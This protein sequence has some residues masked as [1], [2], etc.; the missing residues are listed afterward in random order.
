MKKD[1]IKNSIKNQSNTEKKKN[2]ITLHNPTF[3]N[4]P[5]PMHSKQIYIS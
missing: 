5:Q 4:Q 1:K 3:I 2:A